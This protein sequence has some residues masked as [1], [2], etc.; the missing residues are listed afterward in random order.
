MV[1]IDVATDADRVAVRRLVDGAVLSLGAVSLPERL[2]A[3]DVLL[4]TQADRVHGT[5]IASPDGRTT[6]I[7]AVAVRRRRRGRG[8]GSALVEAATRRWGPLVAACRADVV[9]FWQANGFRV[10]E[11]DGDR[12]TLRR[13]G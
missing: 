10:I 7:V 1:T 2:A 13:D 5:L 8:I 9:G 3:G 4:A 6:R 11:T 12:Y